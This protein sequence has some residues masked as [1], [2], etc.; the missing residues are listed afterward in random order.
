[1]DFLTSNQTSES[2]S[3][4]RTHLRKQCAK[5][6]SLLEKTNPYNPLWAQLG[7]LHGAV[8]Q[9]LRLVRTVIV[10]QNRD[11]VERILFLLSYFIRCGN[12]S[13]YDISQEKFD[14]NQIASTKK[15][16]S[17]GD[18]SK[19]TKSNDNSRP[20][21]SSMST[22]TNDDQSVFVFP[23]DENQNQPKESIDSKQTDDS[24]SNIHELPLIG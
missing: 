23:A 20:S 19:N 22:N 17:N 7:D 3:K 13:Y 5:W 10:G 18:D 4:A 6:T 11:L 2:G 9:P 12:S 15:C 24:L 16:G 8:N 14:F 21:E 1:L